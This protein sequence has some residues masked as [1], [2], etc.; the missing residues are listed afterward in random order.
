MGIFRKLLLI[1]SVYILILFAHA[2]GSADC[3]LT[4]F[5]GCDGDGADKS[6]IEGTVLDVV[7]QSG[8]SGIKIRAERN[9]QRV[10]SKTTNAQGEFKL[11][12]R[13][14][15]ITLLFET[16]TF[17]VARVFTITEDS[18]VFLDVILEPGQVIVGDWQV[19][20]DP[21]HCEGSNAF[22]IDEEDLVDFTLDG[23]GRDCIR[24]KGDC[25]IDI[26]VQN[27]SLNDCNEGIFTENNANLTLE[28]LASPTL[29]IDAESN[30]IHTKNNS[31]VTLT[32]V[33]IFVTSTEANGIL[34]EDFSAVEIQPSGQC[35]IDGFDE[36]I[37]QDVTATV[38]PDGC[39]L[40]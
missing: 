34:A 4:G 27:I 40:E 14:G 15:D 23:N 5:V 30:A 19:L 35:T 6:R 20:Q 13:E 38:D 1:F 25:F 33:D 22:I 26:S 21:I 10:A 24:A 29:T 7:G 36:P 32:G 3:A 9:G 2:C 39:T 12:V 11:K 8:V 37:S 18:E 28:A 17:T 31:S 16:S